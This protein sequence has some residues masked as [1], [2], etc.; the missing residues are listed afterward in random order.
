MR[1]RLRWTEAN[2]QIIE[3]KYKWQHAGDAVMNR[4]KHTNYRTK[5]RTTICGWGCDEQKQKQT[6]YR[7]GIMDD[8]MNDN[9]RVRLRWTSKNTRIIERA[10]W[11]K[12]ERQ[13][14]GVA[15]MNRSENTRIIERA[16]WTTTWTTTCRWCCDEQKR[17]HTNYRE[18]IMD[19]SMN[20]N[21][22]VR[23]RWIEA[24]T[25]EL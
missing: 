8:N 2:I 7:K 5:I 11:T 19:D 14:A 22:R 18:G 4:S 25:H 13:Y 17:K 15:V 6:N 12:N 3:Q 9:M 16:S 21:I 24:K 20:D 23:M 1:V 10:S